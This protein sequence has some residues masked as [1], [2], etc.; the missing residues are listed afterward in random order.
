MYLV[1]YVEA[2]IHAHRIGGVVIDVVPDCA[3]AVLVVV[4]V[5][6]AGAGIPLRCYMIRRPRSITANRGT[7]SSGY[8]SLCFPSTNCG[9]WRR[10]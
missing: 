3:I 8:L 5:I 2:L 4:I 6:T 10:F 7:S 9:P 1:F